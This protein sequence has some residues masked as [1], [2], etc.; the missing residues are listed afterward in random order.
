MTVDAA[1]ITFMMMIS[2]NEK[3]LAGGGGGRGG[4]GSGA[5]NTGTLHREREGSWNS[6]PNR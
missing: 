3:Q 1:V 4:G 5:I 6:R 2:L